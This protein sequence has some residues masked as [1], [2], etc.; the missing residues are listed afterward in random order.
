MERIRKTRFLLVV[1]VAMTAAPSAQTG[2]DGTWHAQDAP[3]SW[4]TVLRSA[5]AKLV[6]AVTSC[7]SVVPV[8]IGAGTI[9]GD[10]ITFT[11]RSPN[12]QRTLTFAGTI[13]GDEITFTWDMQ[14]RPGGDAF[15][16][17]AMF[18][19]SSPRRF[20]AKRGADATGPV[21]E[22]ADRA[23]TQPA[24]TFDRILQ[25]DR[26]PQNW[27]TYSGNLLGHRHSLLRHVTT[28][29]VKDL[30]LAW[31]R[32]IESSGWFEATP[33]VVDGVLYT[34]RTNDVFA[35]DA[36]TGRVHWTYPYT[37]APKARATG[38][39]GRPNRGLAILGNTLF[40]GTLDA[41]LLAIDAFRGTLLW[42]TTVADAHDPSCQG[43]PCYV[44]THA[45]LVV[46]D[47]V[48]VGVAGGEGRTRGFLAAFDAATGTEAWRFQT[49]PGPGEPGHDTWS[50]DSWKIGGA[51]VWNTGAY[52]P[53]LNLTY[54]GIG[55]PSPPLDGS[56]RLGDNLYSNSVVALDAD[57]GKL[58]WH[59]QFT[60][61][62]VQDWDSTQV[63]VLTDL[64]WH[65]QPRKVMLWANRN[66]LLYV[67]DRTT[68]QFLM[69]KPFVEVNWMTGFDQTGRPIQAPDRVVTD[70]NPLR[71]VGATNWSPRSY[72]PSTGLFYVAASERGNPGSASRIGKGAIRAFDM[73]T[74][75]EAWEFKV[76]D[77]VFWRGVLTTAA[78]LLFTGTVGDPDS[79]WADARR[80]D[81]YFYALDARTG[82][83]LWKFGLGATIQ[84]PPMTYAVGG[85]QY[86][87]VAAGDTLFA[88]A[89]RP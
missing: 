51:P 81:N 66:G 13:T 65:G 60:P 64:R 71:P 45:P 43:G 24:V 73:T 74:G 16:T 2:L 56:T 70:A 84:S 23:R 77:A 87:A 29:T 83:V 85:K 79:D 41:H 61:H 82:Q 18:G 47:N 25:A 10:K 36:S 63:P 67:L 59:Y 57:T 78:D 31:I 35:L 8:E 69:G 30:E 14:V 76:D 80:A 89:L 3:A 15:A 33:L 9:E 37:P 11:C 75:T 19:A 26:E 22:I 50:G 48:I 6:G 52:D 54:W 42:N 20:T 58:K 4:T 86:I 55:N 34:V 62:D 7:A 28:S 72:S 53:D 46:K 88:F 44:I 39:G 49:I 17:D 38:G 40:L 21:K 1:V 32:Q 68:G 12:G 27:L 5:G